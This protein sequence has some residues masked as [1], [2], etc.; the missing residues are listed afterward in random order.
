MNFIVKILSRIGKKPDR[1][2]EASIE[3]KVKDLLNIK[4]KPN[5]K[6]NKLVSHIKEFY[7]GFR[8][9]SKIEKKILSH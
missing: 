7:K 9:G 2:V 1:L 6:I 4:R 5:S 3:V 8:F